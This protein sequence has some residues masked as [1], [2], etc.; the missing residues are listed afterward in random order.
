M[1][2]ED[3]YKTE[4]AQYLQGLGANVRRLR[5]TNRP[6]LSQEELAYRARTAPHRGRENRARPRR[7]EA[8]DARPL[9]RGTRG[10]PQRARTGPSRP[11][12]AQAPQQTSRL[13]ELKPEGILEIA[14]TT[15]GPD[16]RP[17]SRARTVLLDRL[18]DPT[19]PRN[20][21]PRDLP[22][23]HANRARLAH[24]KPPNPLSPR[25]ALANRGPIPISRPARHL[26]AH[27]KG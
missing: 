22:H 16:H 5:N 3:D 7:A 27:A 14:T 8:H 1:S 4:L 9:R 18:P 13:P 21:S 6:G 19:I 10:L 26:R 23:P 20:H 11:R 17:Q 2:A 12:P 15:T 24:G 25:A